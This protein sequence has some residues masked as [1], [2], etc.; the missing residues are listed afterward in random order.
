MLDTKEKEVAKQV[1]L[2]VGEGSPNKSNK[3]S[4]SQPVSKSKFAIIKREIQIKLKEDE[5]LESLSNLERFLDDTI[6]YSI[7]FYKDI[8]SLNEESINQL[9][10]VF[11]K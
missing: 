2:W 6:S 1:L 3:N 5:L 4:V 9:K 11:N 10:L 8:K 7:M